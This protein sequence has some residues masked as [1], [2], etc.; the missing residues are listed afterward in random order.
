M[1]VPM[2]KFFEYFQDL[3][4]VQSIKSQ[5]EAYELTE[6]W[7][8]KKYGKNRYKNYDV[9]RVQFSYYLKKLKSEKQ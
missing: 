2:N 3:L 4:T 6:Y 5:K 9:F 7:Y 8:K 1:I